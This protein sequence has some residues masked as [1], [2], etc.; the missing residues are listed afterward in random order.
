[1]SVKLLARPLIFMCPI[2]KFLL[3][4]IVVFSVVKTSS[5]GSDAKSSSRFE[6]GKLASA[7]GRALSSRE[8]QFQ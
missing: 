4:P 1:M 7:K 8:G 3:L 6:S 2:F 5:S